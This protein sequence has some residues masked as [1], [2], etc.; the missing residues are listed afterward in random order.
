M[1]LFWSSEEKVVTRAGIE[2]SVPPYPTT[3][4]TAPKEFPRLGGAK[5][6]SIDTETYDPELLVH[7]PGWA[8]GKGH[9]VGI[10]VATEDAQWYFPMRH[11]IEPEQNLEPEHVL[12]WAKDT[13]GDPRQPKVGANLMYDLGWLRQE[14]V[15]V[16]GK[17]YDVQ[18]AET[19]IDENQWTFSLDNLAKKYLGTA[20]TTEM[21][22][23]WSSWAYGGKADG[24]QRK[25]IY[26]CPPSL[27]GPYAEG[28]A[29]LPFDIFLKQWPIMERENLLDLFDLEIRLIPLLL[30]MRFR[31]VK[32][33]I[34]RAEEVSAALEIAQREQQEQLNHLAGGE[35]V[36]SAN[37]SIAKAFDMA[38]V[39]YPRTDKG[40]PSFVKE[41]LKGHVNPIARKIAEVR[42]IEKMR[43]TFVDGYIKNAH[44]NG[45]VYGQFHPLKGTGHGTVS[46]RFSSSSPNLQNL[47]AR[48]K[49]YGPMIRGLFVPDDGYPS[50]VKVD[51]S[52][53]EYRLLAHYAQ[54]VGADKVRRLYNDNPDIDFHQMTA[55]MVMNAVGIEMDRTTTKGINFGIVYGMGES[56]LGRTL[57]LSEAEAVDLFTTYHNSA[58]FVK[59]TYAAAEKEAQRNGFVLTVLNRRSRFPLWVSKDYEQ[60]DKVLPY[61]T[62]RSTYGM[63]IMRAFTHKALN[64]KLQGSAADIMK[65][66]MVKAYEDG[67]FDAL[68]GP[69]HLTVHDE[70]DLSYHPDCQE[71]LNE[72]VHVLETAVTVSVPLMVQV[73]TGPDWGSAK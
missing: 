48:D 56:K 64:R 12:A 69:P 38:G 28:D 41:F 13:L 34:D 50:W 59:T 62:A 21:L 25:N 24:T 2:K 58:P 29:R 36:V 26:R 18:Y 17:F 6:L 46:G 51:Y 68:G 60:R 66:G 61:D 72:L 73:A 71:A 57:N 7:G 40:A 19:L 67:I 45:R 37:A 63:E 44:V 22:Y 8:R 23:Q 31:G 47:P 42:T 55:D 14:G 39:P 15:I 10:S 9:I 20:K 27:V 49:S 52:Q 1:G 32:V 70:L 65:A 35:V 53:I 33:D 54:G 30:D 16:R 5:A 43:G 4:W 3:G 11:E